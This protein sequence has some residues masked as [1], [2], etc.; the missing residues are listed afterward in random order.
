MDLNRYP[1]IAKEDLGLQQAAIDMGLAGKSIATFSMRAVDERTFMC[2]GGCSEVRRYQVPC[3]L[4][5]RRHLLRVSEPD[6]N[7]H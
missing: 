5:H 4:C 1:S 3:K 2:D 6:D 7:T